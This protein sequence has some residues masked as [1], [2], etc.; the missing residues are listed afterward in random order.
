HPAR[1]ALDQVGDVVD[2]DEQLQAVGGGED[3]MS[4]AERGETLLET[5]EA[6]QLDVR[7]GP[8]HRSHP[9]LAGTEP[10]DPEAIALAQIAE[11]HGAAGQGT[12]TR[13]PPPRFRNEAGAL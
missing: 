13:P 10:A 9:V 3:A 11:L 4:P 8:S 1:I 5:A 6:L 12:D 7:R 2:L